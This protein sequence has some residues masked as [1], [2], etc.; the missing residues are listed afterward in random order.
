MH[1]L[2]SRA[3]VL[4]G[5]VAMVAGCSEPMSSG[6]FSPVA[7]RS[8]LGGSRS[9]SAVIGTAGGTVQVGGNK[10]VFPA[11]ALTSATTITMTEYMGSGRVE[12]QP[13]GLTFPA[14]ARPEL[15]LTYAGVDVTGHDE[16]AVGY[17]VSGQ[18]VEV[19]ASEA[20]GY[21]A[22]A[23]RVPHFSGFVIVGS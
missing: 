10:I 22:V 13:H 16:I 6:R 2:V 4:L 8:T 21:E 11:G 5:L 1:K 19:Y 15:T 23:A 7:P 20:A 17:E 14:A 3:L 12:M 18:V 9:A